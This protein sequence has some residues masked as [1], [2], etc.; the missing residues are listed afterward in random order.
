MGRHLDIGQNVHPDTGQPEG[1][2][3]EQVRELLDLDPFARDAAIFAKL[4][5]LMLLSG[6]R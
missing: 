2:F 3:R 5:L 1:E 4:Q 6:E